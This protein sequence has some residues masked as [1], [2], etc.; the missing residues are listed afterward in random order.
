MGMAF[1]VVGEGSTSFWWEMSGPEHAPT[2]RGDTANA[3][4]DFDRR[5]AHSWKNT[6]LRNL[7]EAQAYWSTATNMFNEPLA[8]FN[9]ARRQ[10]E[11]RFPISG[12]YT[13]LMRNLPPAD[14]TGIDV[15]SY[16]EFRAGVVGYMEGDDRAT[17]NNGYLELMHPT[18]P[19][20]SRLL[21]VF[22]DPEESER[23]QI[24]VQESPAVSKFLATRL[25]QHCERVGKT[26]EARAVIDNAE[27]VLRS[28]SQP[29]D[30]MSKRRGFRYRK[31][32]AQE[33]RLGVEVDSNGYLAH[34]PW[35]E[36]I[37]DGSYNAVYRFTNEVDSETINVKPSLA[38]L[39]I[40]RAAEN[41]RKI[42]SESGARVDLYGTR[43]GGATECQCV[44]S[45]SPKEKRVRQKR[46]LSR[47]REKWCPA[48]IVWPQKKALYR[49]RAIPG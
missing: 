44:I 1:C 28:Q 16:D 14:K 19:D 6:L 27:R 38:G 35:M 42:E 13:W 47:H 36:G 24:L 3:E 18:R 9:M 20:P 33:L 29:S 11:F 17:L 40:G 34:K 2:E 31:A 45:G 30:A 7:I 32:T 22:C 25:A 23:V 15:E 48:V 46:H 37:Q 10:A 39:I 5:M 43:P 49:Y 21:D 41:I 12:A 26:S 4:K 8:S